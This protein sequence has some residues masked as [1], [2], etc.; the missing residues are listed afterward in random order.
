MVLHQHVNKQSTSGQAKQGTHVMC[1]VLYMH[2]QG[3][4]EEGESERGRHT[5]VVTQ[6]KAGRSRRPADSTARGRQGGAGGRNRGRQGLLAAG[7]SR[8]RTCST[9]IERRYAAGRKAEQR[10][11]MCGSA[12]RVARARLRHAAAG[13][14][15]AREG[16][17]C[18]GRER[19]VYSLNTSSLSLPYLLLSRFLPARQADGGKQRAGADSSA[20]EVD[21]FRAGKIGTRQRLFLDS[22]E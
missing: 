14:R 11:G 21:S 6:R 16:S 22:R 18:A 17:G 5:L 15:R 12:S 2:G 8:V 10:A 19:S 20:R 7:G 3:Q 1:S 13:S 4:I 9:S